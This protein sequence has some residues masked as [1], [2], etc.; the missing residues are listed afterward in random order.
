MKCCSRIES[1]IQLFGEDGRMLYRGT[2][3]GRVGGIAYE[4]EP[5]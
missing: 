5:R 1:Q 3:T 4:L 2:N